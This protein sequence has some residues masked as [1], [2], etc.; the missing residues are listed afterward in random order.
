[1]SWFAVAR[2]SGNWELASSPIDRVDIETIW[3]TLTRDLPP[4][5]AAVH[6]ALNSPNPSSESDLQ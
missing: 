2:Y 5:K 3:Y 1:M 6:R 4:L